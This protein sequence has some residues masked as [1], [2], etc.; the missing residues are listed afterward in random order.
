M[1][2]KFA[3]DYFALYGEEYNSFKCLIRL[4]KNNP[5]NGLKY[6]YYGRKFESASNIFT[7]HYYKRIVS[8]LS[9]QYGTEIQFDEKIGG[10]YEV[11]SSLWNNC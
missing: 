6:I 7:R 11:N 1:N 5:N 8:K 10:G 4:L 2:E 9:R 3:K